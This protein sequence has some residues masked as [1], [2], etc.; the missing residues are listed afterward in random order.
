MDRA[1]PEPRRFDTGWVLLPHAKARRRKGELALCAFAPLRETEHPRHSGG[2]QKRTCPYDG[3]PVRREH[4]SVADGLEA[5]RTLPLVN[6]DLPLGVPI[7]IPARLRKNDDSKRH[8]LRARSRS[9]DCRGDSSTEIPNPASISARPCAIASRSCCRG[10]ASIAC[11]CVSPSTMTYT[12][13]VSGSTTSS[14][15]SPVACNAAACSFVS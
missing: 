9:R 6:T 11:R 10:N 14:P 15:R 5:H 12:R 3:L 1:G 13:D 4:H 7:D 8:D 2:V